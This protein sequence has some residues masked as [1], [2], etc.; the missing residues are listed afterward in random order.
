MA[1]GGID[2]ARRLAVEPG[3]A[4]PL[5]YQLRERLRI[6][7]RDCP[8]DSPLPTE[9]EIMAY[10]GVGRATAR[11]AVADLVSEGVLVTRQGSGTYVAPLRVPTELGRRPQGFTESMTRLGRRPTTTVLEA[12]VITVPAELAERLGLAAGAK[13]TMVERLRWLDGEPCMVERAHLPT[14]LVPGLLEHDLTGSLYDLL[15]LHYGLVPALGEESIVAVN[16]DHRLARLLDTPV[17]AALLATSRATRT[18][19]GTRVE[20]TLRHARGDRCAFLV[21]FDASAGLLA[22]QSRVDPSLIGAASA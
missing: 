11:R 21:A 12:E 3:L 19:G 22:D 6:A 13:A 20:Y 7:V 2:W 16:A 15:R 14:D 8:P 17:A 4:M 9:R 1:V 10:T 5:Y 18:E